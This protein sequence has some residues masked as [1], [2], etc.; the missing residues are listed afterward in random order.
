MSKL[1][2]F[3]LSSAE[4]PYLSQA[5]VDDLVISTSDPTQRIIIGCG[6]NA[7][8]G[9]TAEGLNLFGNKI[10]N[11]I[12]EN[13][14]IGGGFSIT[15]IESQTGINFTA[16]NGDIKVRSI[17][18]GD[19]EIMTN[20]VL[21]MIVTQDGNVG[22]G[23][24]I[25][26]KALEVQGSSLVSGDAFYL[27]NVGIGTTTTS[28]KLTIEGNIRTPAGT[29]GPT[30]MIMAPISYID[31]SSSGRFAMDQ[32]MEPGN[33]ASSREFVYQSFLGIDG[34][35]EAAVWGKARFIFR[36]VLM[37][38]TEVSSDMTIERFDYSNTTY[39][40][41][42]TFTISN[43]NNMNKGYKFIV[44]PWFSILSTDAHYALKNVSPA[45]FRLCSVHMQ[46]AAA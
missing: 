37:S 20:D 44:T 11:V 6:S 27:G 35:G 34:S 14:T 45:T 15:D 26:T 29:L 13:L 41:I 36:G 32:T 12:A 9:V 4:Y 43:A 24:T 21:R 42:S 38:S 7:T 25:P 23:T 1:G 2:N 8:M 30:L 22:I 3:V 17:T 10:S 19:V 46:F 33:P 16:S 39:S 40:D 5:A 28:D 18:N 31:I